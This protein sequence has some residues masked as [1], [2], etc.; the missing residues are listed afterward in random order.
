MKSSLSQIQDAVFDGGRCQLTT[1][2]FID[3]LIEIGEDPDV[4]Q[5]AFEEVDGVAV[6]VVGIRLDGSEVRIPGPNQTSMTMIDRL[7]FVYATD[8]LRRKW[9]HSDSDVAFVELGVSGCG[10]L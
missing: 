5:I 8:L 3:R 6:S 9:T 10:C 2:K 7:R 1:S 4:V